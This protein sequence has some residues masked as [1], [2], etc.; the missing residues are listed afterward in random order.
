MNE[1][2]QDVEVKWNK[3][4]KLVEYVEDAHPGTLAFIEKYSERIIMCP[5]ATESSGYGCYPGGLL[6]FSLSVTSNMRLIAKGLSL[7]IP[8]EKI[9]FV[10]LFHAIGTIGDEENDYYVMNDS[11]WHLKKGIYYKYNENLHKMPVSHR[12][13]YL[14]QKHGITMEHDEWVSI[15]ISGGTHRDE[16]KFYIGSEPKLSLLLMQARQWTISERNN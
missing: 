12:S 16:S 4:K 15:M 7:Q 2:S 10:G 6:D 11:D 9:L 14:L 8:Q 5:T 3:F 13:A 1:I